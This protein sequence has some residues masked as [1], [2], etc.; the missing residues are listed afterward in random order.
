MLTKVI[1]RDKILSKGHINSAYISLCKG[2]DY[3]TL[4]ELLKEISIEQLLKYLYKEDF[5]PKSLTD[6]P[7]YLLYELAINSGKDNEYYK[8]MYR[9]NEEFAVHLTENIHIYHLMAESDKPYFNIV[10]WV[11][12]D[13]KKYIGDTWWEEDEEILENLQQLSIVKFLKRY[14][15][16]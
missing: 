2:K 3:S 9:I 16:Y 8:V 1:V 13:S 7:H 15:G 6:S 10:P 11:Y 4:E 14:K 12:A 5:V